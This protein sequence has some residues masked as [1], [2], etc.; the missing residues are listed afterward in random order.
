MIRR[1]SAYIL[2][3][4][5]LAVG[6][7]LNA[8]S[9]ANYVQNLGTATQTINAATWSVEFGNNLGEHTI[10]PGEEV[11]NDTITLTNNKKHLKKKTVKTK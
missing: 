2:V 1:K 7:V 11:S 6:L 8:P 3:G 5:L 4:G 10:F 9:M